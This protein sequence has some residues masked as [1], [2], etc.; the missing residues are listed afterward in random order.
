MIIE[1]EEIC[2]KIKKFSDENSHSHSLAQATE[3]PDYIAHCKEIIQEVL[4]ALNN[5]NPAHVSSL[6][7]EFFSEA[8][9]LP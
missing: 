4:T 5:H 8:G 3:V 7:A 6:E 9:N 2:G 1:N